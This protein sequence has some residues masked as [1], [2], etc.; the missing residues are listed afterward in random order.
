MIKEIR[1]LHD[2]VLIQR[3]D[4]ESKTAGGI[5]IP[6]NAQEKPMQGKVIAVGEGLYE[7]D[8]NGKRVRVPLEVKVG[9]VV[10]FTKWGGNEV[11]I[12]DEEY[13][14]LKESDIMGVVQ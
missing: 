2:R 7:K 6:D 12:D 13:L 3:L 11:K 5:I 9:D 1:P 4:Q 8:C 14:I 10:L